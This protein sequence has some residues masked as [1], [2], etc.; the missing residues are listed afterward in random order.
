MNDVIGIFRA[1]SADAMF[2]LFFVNLERTDNMSITGALRKRAAVP[3]M[4]A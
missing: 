4:Y 2:H 3:L 1:T